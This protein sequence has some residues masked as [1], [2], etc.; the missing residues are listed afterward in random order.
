MSQQVLS[1]EVIEA[2]RRY[3]LG[4]FFLLAFA[5][6]WS[7]WLPDALAAFRSNDGGQG[8][9]GL[10]LMGSFGP[11]LAALVTTA[12]MDGRAGFGKLGRRLLIWRAKP[13]WYAFVLLWP[14]A[15]SLAAT[16]LSLLLGAAVPRFDQP[17]LLEAYPLPP[18]ITASVPW[19]ALL[20]VV[21]LQQ[22]LLGSSM[23]EEPG[24]R[25][26]AL[27][28]MQSAHSSVWASLVL[29]LLWGLWHLP[30]WLGPY[31]LPVSQVGW[32]LLGIIAASVLFTWV[33]NNT[34][35]S[36]LLVMLF[37]ASLAVTG[38]FLAESHVHPA[39]DVV[40]AWL[41]ILAIWMIRRRTRLP[42][43]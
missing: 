23:G 3:A 6:S 14:A 43:R 11:L 39:I 28:R 5:L 4:L 27:P 17:P 8:S 13:Y 2:P 29:G 38:L 26:Y 30:L 10:V 35:G 37:H 18:E 40:L 19:L 33:F 15:L 12:V 25:G 42:I 1:P 32:E 31:R 16:G 22:L 24:W 41:I 20:P 36:L 9:T 21:F 7:A 34:R